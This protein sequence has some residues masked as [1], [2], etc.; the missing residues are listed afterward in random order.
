MAGAA[1]GRRRRADGPV[2]PAALPRRPV[3]TVPVRGWSPAQP[4]QVSVPLIYRRPY[5][6]RVLF[7]VSKQPARGSR[8]PDVC[9]PALG[10]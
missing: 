1:A 10:V 9:W 2:V 4:V 3:P 5:F 6:Y 8:R 7:D